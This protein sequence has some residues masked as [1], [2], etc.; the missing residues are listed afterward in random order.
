MPTKC[1]LGNQRLPRKLCTTTRLADL[2]PG[3]SLG[4][5][6]DEAVPAQR[7]SSDALFSMSA[8]L[9]MMYYDIF[10]KKWHLGNLHLMCPTTSVTGNKG[11]ARQF[12]FGMLFK[13]W[14]LASLRFAAAG[15]VVN[16]D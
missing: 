8:Y 4:Q 2:I 7:F 9:L 16:T 3:L 14:H 12:R 15:S 1:T 6:F 13:P 11:G 10:S 5:A